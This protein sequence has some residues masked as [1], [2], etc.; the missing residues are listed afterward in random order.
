MYWFYN[1]VLC[2]LFVYDKIRFNLF[3]SLL[4]VYSL[5]LVVHD[6]AN[7]CTVGIC[8]HTI[9]LYCINIIMTIYRYLPRILYGCTFYGQGL[10][11]K[12]FLLT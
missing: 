6:A 10:T 12:G 9:I 1:D 8:V 2:L 11:L 7:Y 4:T 5:Y 3:Y